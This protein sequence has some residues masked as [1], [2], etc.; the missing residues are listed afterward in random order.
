MRIKTVDI[1]FESSLK[2]IISELPIGIIY[3]HILGWI[4]YTLHMYP[5]FSIIV[6]HS[7]RATGKNVCQHIIR[8]TQRKWSVQNFN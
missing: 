1:F 8:S 3:F 5:L 2:K 7:Q 4:I 6:W